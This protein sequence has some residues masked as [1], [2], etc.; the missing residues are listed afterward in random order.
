MVVSP[1]RQLRPADLW[2]QQ[3]RI[4]YGL[5][6]SDALLTLG[7]QGRIGARYRRHR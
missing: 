6:R 2:T 3:F 4:G 1:W 5:V 7:E